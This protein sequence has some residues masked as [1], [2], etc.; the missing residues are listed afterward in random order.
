M[1]TTATF[2]S[3]AAVFVLAATF[4]ASAFA[5]D[6]KPGLFLNGPALDGHKVGLPDRLAGASEAAAGGDRD[7]DGDGI[8][9]NG[10]ALD[11][12]QVALPGRPMQAR[13]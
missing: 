6:E 13:R 7:D 1:R 12:Q 4:A 8:I 2:A 5:S 11:G 9:L 3:A 10:P